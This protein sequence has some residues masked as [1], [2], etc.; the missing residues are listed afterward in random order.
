[1]VKLI[2]YRLKAV[3]FLPFTLIYYKITFYKKDRRQERVEQVG[4]YSKHWY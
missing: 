3:I 1:M 4:D 2:F